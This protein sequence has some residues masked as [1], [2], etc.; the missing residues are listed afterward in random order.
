MIFDID[1]SDLIKKLLKKEFRQAK[2]MDL[3]SSILKPYKDVNNSFVEVSDDISYRMLFNGQTMYLR[4]YLNDKYDTILRRI[5]IENTAN[6]NQVF[7]FN[8]DEGQ[9][10]P[11]LYDEAEP[12]ALTDFTY[13]YDDTEPIS[14]IDFIVWV[15]VDIVYDEVVMRA[16]ID[17]YRYASKIYLI[18]TF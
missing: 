17:Q 10:P 11:Y 1:I 8:E 14:V 12:E 5:W 18:Q 15:P 4:H 2:W 16:Q 6:T 9:L 3:I 13:I 7:F